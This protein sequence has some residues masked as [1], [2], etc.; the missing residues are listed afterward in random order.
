MHLNPRESFWPQIST[1]IFGWWHRKDNKQWNKQWTMHDY[2]RTTFSSCEPRFKPYFPAAVVSDP[3]KWLPNKGLP[4]LHFYPYTVY[5]YQLRDIFRFMTFIAVWTL[6]LEFD[7][8]NE[9]ITETK[10][11][12]C[13]LSSSER[14]WIAL[15]ISFTIL[16]KIPRRYDI[17]NG[18]LLRGTD[19]VNYQV[20]HVLDWSRLANTQHATYPDYRCNSVL[21]FES[22][23]RLSSN[24]RRLLVYPSDLHLAQGEE[25]KLPE[26]HL[27]KWHEPSTV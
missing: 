6:S 7:M 22:L 14:F 24:A 25:M 11:C 1:I 20:S 4:N 5:L 26:S 18:A 16:L 19:A 23:H 15:S 13:Q 9:G 2:W 12:F 3:Q 8:R 21:L 27:L 17:W 10:L